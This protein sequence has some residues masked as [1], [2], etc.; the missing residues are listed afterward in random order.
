VSHRF[1]V[2]PLIVVAFLGAGCGS[3]EEAETTGDPGEIA[4]DL[5]DVG[6]SGGAGVRATLVYETP[7]KT[8]VIVDG[9]DEGEPGGGGANPVLLAS[10][11]CDEPKDTLFDLQKLRGSTSETTVELALTALLN[12]DYHIQVGLPDRPREIIACGDIPQEVPQS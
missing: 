10:G 12:G 3:S 6:G 7:E 4:F 1:S 8:T 9:L 2:L 5:K 11:T